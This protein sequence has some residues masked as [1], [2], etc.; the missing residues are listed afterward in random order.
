MSKSQDDFRPVNQL[1]GASPN[2]GPVP[3]NQVIPWLVIL[4]IGLS[5]GSFLAVP[6]HWCLAFIFWGIATY[7]LLTGNNPWRFL[8]RF[9]STP[10]WLRGHPFYT[11]PLE[12]AIAFKHSKSGNR[13]RPRSSRRR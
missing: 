5:L 3:A 2:L 11:S 13:K 7:W 6:W 8:A 12:E 1:L 10:N 9:R 4:V